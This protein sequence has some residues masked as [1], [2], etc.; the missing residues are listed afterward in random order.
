MPQRE[1]C[2]YATHNWG[3]HDERW[4]ATLE[5]AG[6]SVETFSLTRDR[7]TS[8]E[9]RVTLEGGEGPV[10][11]GPLESVT[12]D[13]TGLSRPVVGLSWGFD[14]MDVQTA[15]A[16]MSWL[17][18]L[19]G[20]IVDSNA[21]RDIAIQSGLEQDRLH[22][23]PWGIEIDAFSSDGARAG[24]HDLG[25]PSEVNLIVSLRALEPIY[26]V[27][28]ILD[29]FALVAPEFPNTHL[30][31]GND[32]TLR[33][34]LTERAASHGLSHR[35]H[36][37][38]RLPEPDLAPLLRGARVYVSASEVDGTSVTLLQAMACGTPVVAS[39]TPGNAQWVI[40]GRTGSLFQ[41]HSAESLAQE[42]RQVLASPADPHQIAAARAA[43][44]EH[45]DWHRNSRELATIM[46]PAPRSQDERQPSSF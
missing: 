23:I 1:P 37:I 28:D 20:L 42:L 5:D 29:A 27:A 31:I 22:L 11:A 39:D 44:V 8:A 30:V 41:T 9:L 6:F 36:F 25:L 40:P 14:L 35:I 2:A 12:K 15:G 7:L 21:T 10:L 26:R 16:D 34:E 4:V 18:L 43:V 19:D 24:G 45:A 33:R 3:V 13:L 38:G 46:R 32:G 17:R